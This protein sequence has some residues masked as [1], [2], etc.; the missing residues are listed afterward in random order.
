MLRETSGTKMQK[1]SSDLPFF[2]HGLFNLH[3]IGN[4]VFCFF[5]C[6]EF[7]YNQMQTPYGTCTLFDID[8]QLSF[9]FYQLVVNFNWCCIFCT[10]E[11]NTA[12]NLR[13]GC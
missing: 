3:E 12:A 10:R 11:L 9:H 7:Q 8:A 4:S 1:S 2:A 5:L 13:L 6:Q